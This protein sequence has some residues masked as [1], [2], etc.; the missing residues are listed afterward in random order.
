[1]LRR[2]Y[3]WTM[4]LAARKSAEVWL[5]VIAFVE[6]SVFLV[7]ADVLFL[8]MALSKPER[9]YRYA[10]IATIASVLGGIAGWALGYYAYE[11]VARPVLEFYGKFEDFE[12]WRNTIH[13]EWEILLLLLVT[14]G[15]AHLPPIKVVTIL[16]GVI[17]MNL[18]VFI[19]SAI[20]ARGARFL[21]L[22]WLL[23]RYGEP[24][25]HFVE[26]RLGQIVGIG[27]AALISLAIAYKLFAH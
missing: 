18:G 21:L 1:M 13:G 7:P 2:L 19:I 6:S 26:K 12:Q 15:L 14:S 20:V 11:T 10:V 24:I 5:A 23:R 16:A 25:R 27:A 8:P 17:N 22:A 4:S 3:D 9:S